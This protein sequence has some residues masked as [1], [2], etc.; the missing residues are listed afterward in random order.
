M[1]ETKVPAI[2]A[3][4]DNNVRDV[5]RI[6][7]MILDVRE[8]RAGDPLD[9]NVTY[10]D[11]ILAGALKTR[12]GW[13]PSSSLTPVIPAV[14]G[15]EGYIP[16]NDL[17]IPPQVVG[18]SVTG[19]LTSI[20]LQWDAPPESFRNFAY[21]EVWRSTT[22]QIGNAVRIGTSVTRFYTDA[23]GRTGTQYFYW[24]RFVSQ[25]DVTG[26]FNSTN[27]TVASTGLVGGVDLTDLS[28]TAA[29]LASE[30]V[31]EGKIANAAVTAT[32]IANLAVGNA[33]IQ[34]AAITNA[35]IADLAVDNAKIASLDAAKITTG[36]LSADRIQAG[37]LDAKIVN[38][39]A[40]VIQS[41][42]IASARIAD[43]SITNAKIG[44][45]IQSANYVAGSAGWQINK[46][47]NAE[48][49]NATVRG[50]IRSSDNLFVIDTINKF[51]SISV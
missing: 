51:I 46:N 20:L 9:A 19:L 47:G 30:A 34:N 14:Q 21:V 50:V 12:P 25:A 39:D 28:V 11:L 10:R 5:A 1:S 3:V 41:G 2:P 16:E 18:F 24:V 29:K 22:N 27:G 45:F 31:T 8:G 38:I 32:K 44:D 40:A 23:V 6:F 35:K 7:K 48:F 36:F 49:Q 13:N 17:T 26:G 15:P 42:T 43:G 37:T 4:T 33:A